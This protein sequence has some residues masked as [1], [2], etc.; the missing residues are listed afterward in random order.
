M[1]RE[2][3]PTPARRR[4]S[5]RDVYNVVF[6]TAAALPAVQLLPKL[7][8]IA[9]RDKQKT[10]RLERE[11]LARAAELRDTRRDNL[12]YFPG[13]IEAHPFARAGVIYPFDLALKALEMIAGASSLVTARHRPQRTVATRTIRSDHKLSHFPSAIWRI[14]RIR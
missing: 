3:P 2:L 8:R 6:A 10:E 13:A 1:N 7:A 4:I 9:P 11:R 5:H 14:F 12:D